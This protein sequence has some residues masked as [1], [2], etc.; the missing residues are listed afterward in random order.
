MVVGT[1]AKGTPILIRDIAQVQI[2]PELRRGLA[3]LD[4]KG[5]AV[6][7]IIVMRFGEN[8]LKTIENVKEKLEELQ[9]G[10]PEGVTIKPVYDR[11]GLIERAVETLKSKLIEESIVVAIVTALFLFH[12]PSALVA[13]FTLP[14]A[15]LIA[16]IIMDWQ[17]INANI[18]SLGGIAI[19]IGAMIDAA[20][21]MIENAHKHLERDAGKK[22]HWEIIPAPPRRLGRPSS[23]PCWSSPSPSSR[24]SP[25]ASSQAGC[26]SRSPLPKPMPWGPRRCC[27]SPSSR[28]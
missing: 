16:F 13:I 6:G 8:A 23:I 4:G 12:L 11:S 24:S 2:G 18:M 25:W 21:I 5:E 17:G 22:P 10:L 15:I 26:S 14:V 7:G 19:A 28:C 3:E 1:D 9:A 27:R 20:I